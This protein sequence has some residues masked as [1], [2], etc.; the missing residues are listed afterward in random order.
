MSLLITKCP[1]F[2]AG[3]PGCSG[4]LGF[5]TELGPFRPTAHSKISL[6]KFS[7]N[8]IANIVF[9]E[10]PC[11]VGFSY[12]HLS[13]DYHNGDDGTA[14]DN[15][16]LLQ[17]FFKRFP[18]YLN[19]DMYLISESYGG[20][21]LPTLAK[22]ILEGNNKGEQPVLNFKGF[23]VGNPFTNYFSGPPAMY[24]TYWGHQLIS[25]NLWRQYSESCLSPP[26]YDMVRDT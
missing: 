22:K 26:N 13:S 5:L 4:L 12:S 24:M 25:R 19:H 8:L 1:L 15:Y 3:G 18:E 7:W 14:T 20:H 2:F 11:G 9:I 10:I 6:N 21:Y 16:I 23:A 17:Q